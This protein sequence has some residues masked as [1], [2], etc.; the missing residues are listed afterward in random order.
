MSL[1]ARAKADVIGVRD[2][3]CDGGWLG[4]VNQARV[5]MLRQRLDA[6]SGSLQGSKILSAGVGG[7]TRDPDA[8]SVL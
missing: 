4:S 3:A 6:A 2:A 8:N 1:I 5:R 7:E